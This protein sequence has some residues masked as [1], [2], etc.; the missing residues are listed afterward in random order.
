MIP[1]FEV[2]TNEI[3]AFLISD[4]TQVDQVL[5]FPPLEYGGNSPVVSV[6]DDGVAPVDGTWKRWLVAYKLTV[7]VNR[8]ASGAQAAETLLRQ[9]RKAIFQSLDNH[10]AGTSYQHLGIKGTAPDFALDV[11]D[12]VNYRT[13]EVSF[14]VRVDCYS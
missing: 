12:G 2:V 6:H 10:K 9:L 13:E 14:Q 7:A 1:D 3:V 8:E 5:D 4:L 11:V